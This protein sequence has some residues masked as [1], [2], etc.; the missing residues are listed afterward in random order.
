MQVE[1]PKNSSKSDDEK[2]L[3][4]L[5]IKMFLNCEVS[6]RISYTLYLRLAPVRAFTNRNNVVRA[7]TIQG[8]GIYA[9]RY[10]GIFFN[11]FNI[12]TYFVFSYC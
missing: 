8:G 4:N 10:N 11:S 3:V 9:I 7:D 6:N 5:F 12:I 2:I 1:T